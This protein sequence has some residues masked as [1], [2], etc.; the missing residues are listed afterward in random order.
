M[1]PAASDH[2]FLFGVLALQMD[3]IR[4]DQLGAGMH[5]RVL[6]KNKS[7]AQVLAEWGDLDP[8]LPPG[9]GDAD[10]MVTRSRLS[11]PHPRGGLGEV[12]AARDEHLGR[13]FALKEIQAD[14]L[15]RTERFILGHSLLQAIRKHHDGK[16]RGGQG[17]R[18][19]PGRFVVVCNAMAHAH[20]RGGPAPGPEARQL[21]VWP[22]RM[23]HVS[24]SPR[25]Q[26][27]RRLPQ[28]STWNRSN[29][30][31]THEPTSPSIRTAIRAVNGPQ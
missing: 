21:V 27:R 22:R 24:R 16:E 29:R 14:K 20:A 18:D 12:F 23:G 4:R 17:L 10:S 7:L 1:A 26:R 19:L 15:Q 5:A 2:N 28:R 11:R 25:N 8:P 9:A 3:L 31:T 30:Q 6:V 13:T